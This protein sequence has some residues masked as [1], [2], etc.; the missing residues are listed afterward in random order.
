MLP[1]QVD[2]AKDDLE[3]G[4]RFCH[5]CPEYFGLLRYR[6]SVSMTMIIIICTFSHVANYV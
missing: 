5:E 6:T 2:S 4:D 3:S 1:E